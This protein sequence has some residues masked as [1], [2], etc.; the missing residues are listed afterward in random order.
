MVAGRSGRNTRAA[1]GANSPIVP[2][3]PSQR[4]Q[5]PRRSRKAAVPTPWRV[6]DGGLFVRPSVGRGILD[7]PTPHPIRGRQGCRPLRRW[8]SVMRH[9]GGTRRSRPTFIVGSAL[10]FMGQ[11]MTPAVHPTGAAARAMACG[12][13]LRHL[14]MALGTTR[15]FAPCA[16]RPEA[17]PLDS[18]IF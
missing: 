16:A 9:G 12:R 2:N 11:Q 14:R 7:A 3:R 10:V 8:W 1:H 15:G 18:A 13:G 17:L 6:V 5:S 4:A